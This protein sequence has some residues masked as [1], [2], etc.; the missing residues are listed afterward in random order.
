METIRLTTAQA[1]VRWLVN[2]YTVIDGTEQP[3]FAGVSAI[4]GHGN[5]TCLGEALEPVRD[6]L[7]TWHGHNEQAMRSPVSPSP[8]PSGAARS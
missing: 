8:R 7:P 4:F 1:I 3:L 2:Q 5:V 6:L